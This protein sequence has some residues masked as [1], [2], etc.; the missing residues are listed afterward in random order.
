[1]KFQER[2]TCG[3]GQSLV[4]RKANN[5]QEPNCMIPQSS[6]RQI[7]L[8]DKVSYPRFL[9]SELDPVPASQ[10]YKSAWLVLYQIGMN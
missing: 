6:R 10:W 8:H 4:H 5:H 3:I 1:M 9:E 7:K 2:L